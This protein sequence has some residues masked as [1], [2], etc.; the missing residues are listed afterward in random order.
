MHTKRLLPVAALSLTAATLVAA[1]PSSAAVTDARVSSNWSGYAASGAQFSKVSGSWVQPEANCDSG[2]GDAAF[3][4]GLGGADGQSHALEQAGTEVDCSSGS[5]DYSAWYELV[6]AA[7]VK[8]DNL[9]VSPGDKITTTVGVDGTQVSIAMTNETTGQNATKQL[10]MDNPDV[11]SAEW[12]AEAPSACQGGSLDNCTPVALADFGTID[13]TAAT[14]TAGGQTGPISNWSTT[15]MQLSPDAQ[16]QFAG[17]GFGE[18]GAQ[19]QGATSGAGAVPSDLGADGASFSVSVQ[20]AGDAQP[21]TP[22]VSPDAQG[23]GYGYGDGG[24]GDYGYGDGG[25]GWGGDPGYGYG[26]GF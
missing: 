26:Y 12:I 17:G 24:Y 1:A 19:D 9:S 8:F 16:N 10:Q 2:S 6:P 25:Y 23:D 5:P 7:P 11:S 22:D 3:W 14:A 18:P 21:S 20:N 15:A 13:F 4:V